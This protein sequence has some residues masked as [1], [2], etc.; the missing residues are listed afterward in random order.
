MSFSVN[1]E[2][3]FAYQSSRESYAFFF[4]VFLHTQITA[5]EVKTINFLLFD[6]CL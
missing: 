3:V 2:Y 1:V 4:F 5:D 6:F